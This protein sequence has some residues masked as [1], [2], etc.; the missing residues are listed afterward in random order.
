MPAQRRVPGGTKGFGRVSLRRKTRWP[1]GTEP[2]SRD[3]TAPLKSEVLG[4]PKTSDAARGD[5]DS[6]SRVMQTGDIMRRR[7]LQLRRLTRD[8]SLHS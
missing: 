6:T 4:I 1:A 7:A 2:G 3:A 8:L 5:S